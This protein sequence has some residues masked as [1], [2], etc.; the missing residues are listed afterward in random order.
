[1]L[2]RVYPQGWLHQPYLITVRDGQAGAATGWKMVWQLVLLLG[3]RKG[4]EVYTLVRQN[5]INVP[6]SF[7]SPMSRRRRFLKDSTL[8]ASGTFLLLCYALSLVFLL[9]FQYPDS[10]C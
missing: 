1:M 9:C 7:R 6:T 5:G 2:N 8:F 10:R 3:V 4:W